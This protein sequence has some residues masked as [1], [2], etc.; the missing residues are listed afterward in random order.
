MTQPAIRQRSL[1]QSSGQAPQVILA[2]RSP[3]RAQLL[4][5][6]GIQFQVIASAV[7]E[8]A[9][10]ETDPQRRSQLLARLKAE[11]VAAKQPHALVIG[12]DTLVEANDE[13]ILEKPR[14]VAEAE[15]M[16]RRQRG[17]VSTVHSALHV[18]DASGKAAF[19]VS[20][21]AV[22]FANISDDDITWWIHTGL[23][24]DRSGAFQI[25]GPGQ[26]LVEHVAGDWTGVVGLP[27]FL[28]G[29]LLHQLNVQ[30]PM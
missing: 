23:W 12:C 15:A 1:R 29:R 5:S 4:R 2:S 8:S 16:L 22:H 7:D 17:T 6:L 27:V 14:D 24:Q 9:C 20:S 11:D 25:E 30:F 19:G 10:R 21:T 28:L 13:T 26:L 3:Q 18:I